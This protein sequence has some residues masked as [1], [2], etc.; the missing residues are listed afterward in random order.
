MTSPLKVSSFI[1][2]NILKQ[3]A[4]SKGNSPSLEEGRA[5]GRPRHR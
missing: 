1:V 5:L 2:N 4:K 3:V